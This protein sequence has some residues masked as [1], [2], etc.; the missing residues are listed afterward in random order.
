M[1]PTIGQLKEYKSKILVKPEWYDDGYTWGNIYKNGSNYEKDW[2]AVCY[3]PESHFSEATPNSN[4]YYSGV[5]ETGFTHNDLLKMCFGN[6]YM[7]DALFQEL[8][9]TSPDV[10]LNEWDD[11]TIAYFYRFI[12]RGSLVM[13]NDPSGQNSGKYKVTYVPFLF[14]ELGELVDDGSFTLETLIT[15]KNGQQT[16]KVPVCQLTKYKT[17]PTKKII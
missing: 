8:S 2:D 9:W 3:I 16:F 15:I 11:D 6:E 5:Y 4:G 1:Y 7:C 17:Q 13:W 14:D 12:K 10:C